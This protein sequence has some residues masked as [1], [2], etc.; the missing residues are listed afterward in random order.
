MAW[1]LVAAATSVQAQGQIDPQLSLPSKFSGPPAD[2]NHV[3]NAIFSSN[4]VELTTLSQRSSRQ[5]QSALWTKNSNPYDEWELD[6]E[7]NVKGT[8]D[9]K[10]KNKNPGGV[11]LWYT[12]QPLSLGGPAHGSQDPWDGLALML[13]SLGWDKDGS[14]KSLE[15]NGALRAHLNDGTRRFSESNAFAD[16]FTMCR[17]SYRNSAGATTLKLRNTRDELSLD[18]NGQKCFTTHHVK[19]PPH[20]YF[21]ISASGSPSDPDAISVSKFTLIGISRAQ[22]QQQGQQPSQPIQ[23]QPREAPA[24]IS[25]QLD[26]VKLDLVKSQERAQALEVTIAA[27]KSQISSLEQ[28]ASRLETMLHQLV[29][30][31]QSKDKGKFEGE[32]DKLHNRLESLDKAMTEYTTEK[33]NTIKQAVKKGGVSL[34]VIFVMVIVIQGMLLVGYNVYKTRRSYHRKIL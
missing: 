28:R 34:W 18:I 17:V 14:T 32:L 12:S 9:S 6:V 23:Q 13:D 7:V 27:Q 31:M 30:S 33:M 15:D 5:Q 29:E 2:W 10:T 4:N 24:V 11:A 8:L 16:A 21:G 26:E 3:G 19:L 25:R 20:Y 1:T 22:S